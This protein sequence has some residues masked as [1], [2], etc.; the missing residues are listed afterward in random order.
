MRWL[1]GIT[2]SMDMSLNKL[3]ELVMDREAWHAAV[4]G[5][6]KSQTGQSDWTEPQILWLQNY[7]PVMGWTVFLPKF[8]CLSST[9]E[10]LR[11]WH[12]LRIKCESVVSQPC[13]TLCNTMNCTLPCSSVH[14]TL[15][16]RILE[17]VAIPFS[18]GSSQ[19]RNQ[20]QVSCIV[21]RFFTI[22]VTRGEQGHCRSH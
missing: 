10:S 16:A 9:S 22:W 6:T 1:D 3:L 7:S 17:W 8:I 14:G 19:P 20:T 5:D 15:Q 13:P 18:R 11:M 2:D 12:Y 4:H 21:G